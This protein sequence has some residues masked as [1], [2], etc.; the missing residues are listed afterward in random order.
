MGKEIGH[1]IWV[2]SLHLKSVFGANYIPTQLCYIDDD[3]NY[4]LGHELLDE[5]KQKCLINKDFKIELGNI[6]PGISI[7][8]TRKTFETENGRNF[9]AYE[10]TKDFFSKTLG[11]IE[12]ELKKSATDTG[13][14]PAKILVAEPLA[15]QV[16][17]FDKNW[18][19][20]YR[21]NLRRILSRY[22]AVEFLPEPFAVYQYY[23][24][25]LRVPQ[26]QDNAKH[27][28]LIIDFGGGTF[29]ICVIESTSKGDISLSGKHSKPL[30]SN[31]IPVGGF[32][33]NRIIAKYLI[34]RDLD[35]PER[36]KAVQYYGIYLRVL[37][38]EQKI[39][40][41]NSE[42]TSFIRNI[43]KLEDAVETYKI[44][45]VEKISDWD[46]N[47]DC[48]EKIII[49]VPENP[50]IEGEL[51]TTEFRGHELRKLIIDEIW[52][53]KLEKGVK[54]ALDR[55][56]DD[57]NG[58]NITTTLVSGGSS[59]I[60]WILQL[61]TEA[62]S[63][64]LSHAKPLSLSQSFQEIVA[65]GLAIECARRYYEKSSEFVSV[66][67][68]P[69]HLLLD[70]D[71]KGLE[72]RPFQSVE[73]KIDMSGARA[74]DLIPS[75][76]SLKYFFDEPLQWK[77][78]LKHPPK[79][80]LK[81]YFTRPGAENDIDDRYNYDQTCVHT[82]VKKHFDSQIRVE[83]IVSEDGTARPKFIYKVGNIGKGIAENSEMAKPF[84][85]DMT[86]ESNENI[87]LSR[88]IGF[89]FGTSNSSISLLNQNEVK[90][91]EKRQHNES[92][93]GLTEALIDLPYPVAIALRKYLDVS[94]A[95]D[96]V[97]VAREA[98][99]SALAFLSYLAASEAIA[100]DLLGNQMKKFAHRSMGPLRELLQK[101][102]G[103]LGNQAEFSK[104]AKSLTGKYKN[105][106]DTALN[107][108]NNH[109]H[110]KL[111]GK[112]VSAHDHLVMIINICREVMNEKYF[113]FTV[114]LEKERFKRD[115]YKGGFKVAHDNQ[116]FVKRVE[117][118]TEQGF[119]EDEAILIDKN[120]GQCLTMSPLMFWMEN[121]SYSVPYNCYVYDKYDEKV[122][123][124]LLKPCSEK[125]LERAIDISEDLDSIYH[126][127]REDGLK[128]FSKIQ[129][130][131]INK[132]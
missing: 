60:R 29:D 124:F 108:F 104:P 109:K 4:K 18:I 42:K 91:I 106:F 111:L 13:K 26:L 6:K 57:L 23:R 100:H 119:R 22:E 20:N 107:E 50:F 35:G 64:Q 65:K 92:W 131:E 76:Q 128:G 48:Y 77:V 53:K 93:V 103:L 66:T 67:Y 97:S 95:N 68:N 96:P 62:F 49:Q 55:A 83:L 72:I 102:L 38:G 44:K 120:N 61:I 19:S 99:E 125:R 43:E 73:R 75:A 34:K 88:Y 127:L 24:Y 27:I 40:A 1:T 12:N 121:D 123:Q 126:S 112:D 10:L 45:L 74:G 115:S 86:T 105:Q 101:S 132:T 2:D 33:I 15:F 9:T 41:L 84:A 3:R 71:G 56:H 28:A 30:A 90:I 8:T 114:N 47:A 58:G 122:D 130:I 16:A 14:F 31:S 21:E 87:N 80:E 89:D 5:E 113:G 36:R 39:S 117:I 129:Q 59:N 116:P 98:F 118:K 25:G 52:S 94:K 46:I 17:E 79:S 69:I 78:K 7:K 32:Y 82:R 85:L 54:K 11:E 51:F 37:K 63:D 110:D 70:P 81:Y